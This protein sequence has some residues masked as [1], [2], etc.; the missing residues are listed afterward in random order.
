[1]S[2]TGRVTVYK[3]SIYDIGSDEMRASRRMATR[4]AIA[5]V[6]GVAFEGSEL[7]IDAAHVG[8]EIPGMTARDFGPHLLRGPGFQ[9]SV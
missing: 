4:D 9:R 3:F 6:G 2:E 1:M 7:E 5:R 8:Q